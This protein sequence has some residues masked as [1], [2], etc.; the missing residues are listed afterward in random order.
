MSLQILPAE[1]AL[2]ETISCNEFFSQAD[3]YRAAIF[4]RLI[5]FGLLKTIQ[6]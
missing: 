1:A 6:Y 2:H 4:E 5:Y 3:R